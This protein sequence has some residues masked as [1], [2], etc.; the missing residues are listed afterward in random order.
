MIEILW[1]WALAALPL[2]IIVRLLF[3]TSESSEQKTGNAIKV[4][5]YSQILGSSEEN[6]L[7]PNTNLNFILAFIIWMVFILAAANPV[8]IGEP[9]QMPTM[10]R[11]LMLAIDV[12]PS[13]QEKDMALG[14]Q[15]VDRL[16]ILKSVM[17]NFIDRREGD[18]LGLILFGSKAYLQTPLT[19]DRQTV[20]ILLNEAQIGIAGK[21]TAIGD[22]IGMGLKKLIG[23]ENEEKVLILATDGANT[24][25]E[26][27]PIKAAE[28]AALENMTI[29]TIGI[30]AD[31]MQLPGIFGSSFG[32]R[33]INPSRDLDEKML[34][35]IADITGGQYF[36]AKSSDDLQVIYAQLDNLEPVI[37][38]NEVYR[39]K[40]SLFYYPLGLAFIFSLLLAASKL[41]FQRILNPIMKGQKTT[42]T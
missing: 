42:L 26:I 3:P 24:A 19:L 12:S 9:I 20:N 14:G 32:S 39:P 31:S 7:S 22:A 16:T 21:A 34:S 10:G 29:Y 5:F 17:S 18:R 27:N 23:S 40:S 8:W 25:G 30:G 4:P 11:N 15:A 36:R 38:D 1:P 33:T 35:D 37:G 2:P 41:P 28:L 6:N 13:M